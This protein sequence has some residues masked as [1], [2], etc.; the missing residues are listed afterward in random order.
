MTI[1]KNICYLGITLQLD[2]GTNND[3][4]AWSSQEGVGW[5]LFLN[6][7]S[8]DGGWRQQQSH[9]HQQGKAMNDGIPQG[10]RP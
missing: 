7:C 6:E 4:H 10:F 9:T 5:D 2:H 1:P 3:G 8:Q